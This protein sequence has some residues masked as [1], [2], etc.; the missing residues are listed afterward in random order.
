MAEVN[1]FCATVVWYVTVVVFIRHT[2]RLCVDGTYMYPTLSVRSSL[3]YS[4]G[5][6]KMRALAGAK[7]FRVV[8]ESGLR[9]NN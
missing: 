9:T 5:F 3:E 2:F 7:T 4:T 6:E 8:T 1:V